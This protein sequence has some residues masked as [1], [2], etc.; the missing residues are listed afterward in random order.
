MDEQSFAA[1]PV[2]TYGLNLLLCSVAYWILQTRI[3]HHQG[4]AGPLATALGRDLKAKSSPPIYVLGILATLLVPW[5]GVTVYTVVA[6]MWLVP[7][8]RVERYLAAH[9]L[10][11]E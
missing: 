4:K 11:E 9:D 10:A 6:L 2:V 7:D 1:T 8:R 5:L 3:I